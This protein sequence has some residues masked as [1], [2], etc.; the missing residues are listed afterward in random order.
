MSLRSKVS[1]ERHE[2]VSSSSNTIDPELLFNLSLEVAI[3]ELSRLSQYR[4]KLQAET[5]DTQVKF[6]LKSMWRKVSVF[7]VEQHLELLQVHLLC[8]Y[9]FQSFKNKNKNYIK[10]IFTDSLLST[11][12]EDIFIQY[13]DFYLWEINLKSIQINLIYIIFINFFN[14]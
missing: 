2:G 9:K 4:R 6:A 13:I 1:G 3:N 7:E 5:N 10:K 8:Y 14:Y 12:L 11:T